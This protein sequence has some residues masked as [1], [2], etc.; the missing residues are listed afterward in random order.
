MASSTT[1][2]ERILLVGM[3]GSGKTTV[4]RRL[5]DRLGWAYVDSDEQIEAATGRTVR[6]I[7]EDEGEPAFRT[8][9]SQA[10]R[11]AVSGDHDAVVAVAGGAVLAEDNRELIASQGLVVWLRAEPAVLTRRA[12][13]GDHRPLLADDPG[14]VI[15]RLLAQREPIYRSLADVVVDVDELDPDAAVAAILA[16]RP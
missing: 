11:A 9:E 7:F 1:F 2:A 3:M 6:E 12:T 13:I 8:L 14:G 15:R 16:A 5:A 10:L 4:G